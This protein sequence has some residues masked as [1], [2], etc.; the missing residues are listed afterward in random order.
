MQLVQMM[1]GNLELES[2][3]GAGSTFRVTIPIEAAAPDALGKRSGT[4][5]SAGAP[6]PSGM[7]ILLAE[8]HDVNQQLF[9]DMLGQL[10]WRADL[11]ENGA[12]AVRMVEDANAT[13]DPYGVVLMDVQM[14]VMDGLEATR[15][16]RE[17]GIAADRLPILSLTA[18]AYDSDIAACFAAGS[19]AH[20]AKPIKM[21]D[22]DRALRTWA[23]LNAGETGDT[24]ISGSVR[25]L[26]RQR[27]IETLQALDDL[28]RQGHFSNENLASVARLLHK[29]AGTAAMFGDAELGDQARELEDGIQRWTDAERNAKIAAAVAE[30]R[31]AA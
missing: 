9:M 8:D 26:Y 4:G 30:I 25:E 3:S 5:T 20:L 31:K 1:G 6:R 27:K 14:P 10:G 12:E 21:A 23:K 24:A 7:R 11:A 17:S 13:D 22:L 29:L 28:V 15:R 2:E 18:N 16:I 19:Q